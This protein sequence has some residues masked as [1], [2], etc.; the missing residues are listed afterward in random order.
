MCLSAYVDRPVQPRPT[1]AGRCAQHPLSS[2]DLAA[3][4]PCQRSADHSALLSAVPLHQHVALQ[5]PGDGASAAALHA[6]LG[7]APEAAPGACRGLG[8]EA[9][10]GTG[11]RLSPVQNYSGEGFCMVVLAV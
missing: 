1:H 9:G 6:T 4:L 2:H 5:H 8:G 10:S 11:R 3:P 7:P